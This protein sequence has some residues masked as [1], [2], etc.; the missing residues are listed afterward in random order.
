MK[1]VILGLV[2]FISTIPFVQAQTIRIDFERYGGKEFIYLFDK[3]DKKDTIATG[4]LDAKG[5]TALELPKEKKG[6]AGMSHLLVRDGGTADF[7]VNKENLTIYSTEEQFTPESIKFK[8]SPENEF[9]NE[10]LK[11]NNALLGKVIMLE[12]AFS[13][14]KKEDAFYP[15]LEKE[16]EI[17]NEQ[18]RIKKSNKDQSK[19]YAAKVTDIYDFLLGAGGSV[20][21]PLEE[22]AKEANLF[23]KEK[24][25]IEALYTSGYWAPVIDSWMQLQQNIIKDDKILLEDTKQI[26]SRIKDG[27]VYAAF[28]EK[29]ILLY[30]KMGKDDLVNSLTAYVSKSDLLVKPDKNLRTVLSGPSIGAAA[31]ALQISKGKK[32]INK[33]TVLFFYESGCNNCENEIHQ[34]IG[35]YQII[36][37]KG[38]EVISVAADITN[39][40]GEHSHDF[41]WAEQLCDYKGFAGPNF[42]NYGIIGTPMFFVIDNKGKITGRFARL[43]DTGILSNAHTMT[44]QE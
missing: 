37:E 28:A 23:V 10:R 31:P 13:I 4:T 1:K 26:L 17:I 24:L 29:I 44:K 7:I 14:Y 38:Y 2:F 22:K 27:N 36:K 3:G 33:K 20:N 34:L 35:N 15:A 16:K 25:D 12:Y 41:P 6:Y 30:T 11:T 32:W 9:L 21:Q 18:L 8:D 42:Q 5:K 19:L 39:E 40:A 43:V